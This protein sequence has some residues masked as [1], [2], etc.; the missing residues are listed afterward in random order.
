[1]SSWCEKIGFA[2][3]LGSVQVVR[4]D[5]KSAF[6]ALD[7]RSQSDIGELHHIKSYIV[8]TLKVKTAVLKILHLY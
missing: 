3:C 2:A 6:V 7:D 8:S 5:E 1:M 4:L